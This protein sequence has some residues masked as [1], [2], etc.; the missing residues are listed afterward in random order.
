MPILR[1]VQ[2]FK[3]D[4]KLYPITEPNQSLNHDQF[5]NRETATNVFSDLCRFYS[6]LLVSPFSQNQADSNK[7]P[8]SI[9]VVHDIFDPSFGLVPYITYTGKFI[10]NKEVPY[11]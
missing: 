11:V 3:V 8:A 9:E 7:H 6:N 5:T 10:K 4:P 2:R 1:Q